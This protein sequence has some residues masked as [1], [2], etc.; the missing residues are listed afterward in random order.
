MSAWANASG[1]PRMYDDL[2]A[3]WPLL[4]PPGDYEE[5]I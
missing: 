3:W 5:E 1:R 2:A 4:S